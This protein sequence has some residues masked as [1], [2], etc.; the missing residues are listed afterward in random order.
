[1]R[2]DVQ[3]LKKCLS[4]HLRIAAIPV[5]LPMLSLVTTPYHVK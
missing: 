1:M 2:N 4:G 3:T 5:A